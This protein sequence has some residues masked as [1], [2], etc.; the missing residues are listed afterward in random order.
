[1]PT[2]S[3]TSASDQVAFHDD[4][5]VT[6]ADQSFLA[7]LT[8]NAEIS[9]TLSDAIAFLLNA[10][11]QL[12]APVSGNPVVTGNTVAVLDFLVT[13][14][15][16]GHTVADVVDE[17]NAVMVAANADNLAWAFVPTFSVSAVQKIVGAG[18]IPA[19][20][21]AAGDQ[22]GTAGAA[23]RSTAQAAAQ[24][25]ANN[26]W[27]SQLEGELGTA[28]KWLILGGAVVAGWWLYRKARTLA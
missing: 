28:G 23:D 15:G 21:P 12:T 9:S 8:P 3:G 16:Q 13:P 6:F 24:T 26:D 25:A 1:M 2:F 19:G 17:L 4:L 10:P 11:L 27:L 22:Y 7:A 20:T 14:N 18:A 5:R